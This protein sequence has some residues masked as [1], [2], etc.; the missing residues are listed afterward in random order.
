MKSVIIDPDILSGIPVVS[1]TCIPAHDVAAILAAGHS[2]QD[3]LNVYDH[4]DLTAELVLD[5]AA[6]AAEHPPIRYPPMK[7]RPPEGTRLITRRT[8]Q[9]P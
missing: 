6:W 8:Y 1:G 3:V 9:R 2:V 4:P 5:A 7:G